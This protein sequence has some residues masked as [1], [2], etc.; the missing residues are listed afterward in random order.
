MAIRAGVI[1]IDLLGNLVG[2]DAAFARAEK[3][4][5]ALAERQR[6]VG[7][8]LTAGITLP[9]AGAGIA[10]SKFEGEFDQTMT[11]L[12]T[13]AS[14]GEGQM[15]SFRQ[16]VLQLAPAVGRG[17][18]ELARALLAIASAG[19]E[20]QGA[21]DILDRSARLAAIGL[22]ETESVARALTSVL[23][24]YGAKILSAAKP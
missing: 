4:L 14:V 7:S 20:G 6:N 18:N 13:L 23:N 22:G 3:S 5:G 9:L 21:L 1:Q 12:V 15:Q 8:K 11:R 2:L 17:P 16:A 24:A 19:Q 10:A